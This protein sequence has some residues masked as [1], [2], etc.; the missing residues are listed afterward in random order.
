MRG[1]TGSFWGDLI[2]Y[3]LISVMMYV[4]VVVLKIIWAFITGGGKDKGKE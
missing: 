2:A 4:I 1:T 3:S